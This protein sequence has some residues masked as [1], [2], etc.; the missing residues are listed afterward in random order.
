MKLLEEGA[1]I[2]LVNT[3]NQGWALSHRTRASMTT[4]VVHSL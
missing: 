1:V 4:T 2:P 3:V